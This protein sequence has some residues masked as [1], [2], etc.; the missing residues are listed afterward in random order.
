MNSFR[1]YT[2]TT[3]LEMDGRLERSLLE[4]SKQSLASEK[5]DLTVQNGRRQGLFGAWRL[6]AVF[7]GP[8]LVEIR[9]RL[10]PKAAASFLPC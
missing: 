1:A 8:M 6:F 4:F 10:P 9:N 7:L 5:F 3:Y 2:K